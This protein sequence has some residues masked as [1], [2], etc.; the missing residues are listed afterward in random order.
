[1]WPKTLQNLVGNGTSEV[2]AWFWFVFTMIVVNP[3]PKVLDN[4]H[5]SSF[6]AVGLNVSTMRWSLKVFSN[7]ALINRHFF[8]QVYIQHWKIIASTPFKSISTTFEYLVHAIDLMKMKILTYTSHKKHFGLYTK[9]YDS[10]TV[11]N[12]QIEFLKKNKC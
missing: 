9:V 2:L 4:N 7:W 6:F 1:M 10:V 5:S 11:N 3:Y 8:I 12:C